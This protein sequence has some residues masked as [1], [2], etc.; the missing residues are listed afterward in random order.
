V[1][2]R[3]DGFCDYEPVTSWFLEIILMDKKIHSLADS[4]YSGYF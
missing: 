4:I 3:S 2:V 1:T